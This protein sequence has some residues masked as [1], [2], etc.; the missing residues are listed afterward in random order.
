MEVV[1]PEV[2]QQMV[3]DG[4]FLIHQQ[5]Q[6][7]V[8]GISAASARKLQASGKLPL[9][10]LDRVADVDKLRDSGFQ[11]NPSCGHHTLERAWRHERL[12]AANQSLSS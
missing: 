9:L 11:V 5:V 2:A 4:K 1:L 6:G 10:D 7:H 8:Y 3:A 12:S